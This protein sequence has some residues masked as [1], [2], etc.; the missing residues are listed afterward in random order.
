MPCFTE[1]GR[2][3]ISSSLVFD[4]A[5]LILAPC[6]LRPHLFVVDLGEVLYRIC[7]SALIVG[8]LCFICAPE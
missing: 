2:Y 1:R 4:G 8:T 7:S 6:Y 3:F 5:F